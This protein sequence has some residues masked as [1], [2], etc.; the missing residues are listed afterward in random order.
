M[1]VAGE[2]SPPRVRVGTLREL[3]RRD[4]WPA[5]AA[6]LA[7][8]AVELGVF[9]G[10]LACGVDGWQSVMASLA[11]GVVWVSRAAP[12]MAAGSNTGWGALLR[13]TPS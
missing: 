11:A 12:A 10:A 5:L 7:T 4:G 3:L 2:S 9:L 13:N 1:I 6:A 8:M